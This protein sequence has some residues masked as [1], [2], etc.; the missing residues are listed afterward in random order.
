MR[1]HGTSPWRGG[2]GSC[3]VVLSH[4]AAFT[5]TGV[6]LFVPA[7]LWHLMVFSLLPLRPGELSQAL[8]S[9][10]WQWEESMAGQIQLLRGPTPAP[11]ATGWLPFWS[12]LTQQQRI[13]LRHSWKAAQAWLPGL[14]H[15]LLTL[16]EAWR[17]P[18][19]V[20]FVLCLSRG[21]KR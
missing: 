6:G 13:L 7:C 18:P 21:I 15:C 4:A 3:S 20:D 9:P 17:Y 14:T 1:G 10:C 16:T 5:R 11:G 12:H 19:S 8:L 2:F